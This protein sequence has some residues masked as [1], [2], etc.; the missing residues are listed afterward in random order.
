MRVYQFI[1]WMA[2]VLLCGCTVDQQCRTAFDV[3]MQAV[4]RADSLQADST[5]ATYAI[6][7]SITVQGLGRDSVLYDN[8]K[9]ITTLQLPLRPDTTVTAYRLT[10]HGRTDTLYIIHNND[11]Q[12]ISLACG[13]VIYHT[14]EGFRARGTWIDSIAMIDSTV[15]ATVKDNIRLIAH[16]P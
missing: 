4:F 8:R 5:Y 7:D 15:Q 6:W 12:F 16:E 3:R 14:I 13:E 1:I 11:I 2:V 10:Y 9:G